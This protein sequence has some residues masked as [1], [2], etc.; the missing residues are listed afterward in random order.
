MSNLRKSLP[1]DLQELL[2]KLDGYWEKRK[3]MDKEKL[4]DLLSKLELAIDDLEE[5]M[6]EIEDAIDAPQSS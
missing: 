4:S 5:L 2:S 6:V 1:E 3:E